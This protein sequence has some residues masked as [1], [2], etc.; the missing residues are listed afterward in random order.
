MSHTPFPLIVMRI[1]QNRE[2][3]VRHK[4][5]SHRSLTGP[6]VVAQTILKEVLV[7]FVGKTTRS[8]S[9][10]LGIPLTI[11]IKEI[12]RIWGFHSQSVRFSRPQRP[13][14]RCLFSHKNG[15][16]GMVVIFNAI[17]GLSLVP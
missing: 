12:T 1:G 15:R 17:F 11:L 3:S 16:W 10:A 8:Y 5:A 13:S 2:G 6:L 9:P 7:L 4:Y 14:V